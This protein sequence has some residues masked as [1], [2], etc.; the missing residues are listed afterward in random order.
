[1]L[2]F[3][4]LAETGM[5]CES[6]APPSPP[7]RYDLDVR[8]DRTK[9]LDAQCKDLVTRVRPEW[10]EQELKGKVGVFCGN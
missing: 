9:D 1:M 10:A 2:I 6:A 7:F 4:V 8:I 5:M 3:L